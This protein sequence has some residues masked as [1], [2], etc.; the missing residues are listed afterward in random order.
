MVALAASPAAKAI[1]TYCADR[2]CIALLPRIGKQ[3]VGSSDSDSLISRTMLSKNN[4]CC[5]RCVWGARRCKGAAGRKWAWIRLGKQSVNSHLD[6][7][8]MERQGS[9]DRLQ[10]P[11]GGMLLG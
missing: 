6:A 9:E 2:A 3:P 7:C 1:G 4:C 5:A 10:I 8:C 11:D